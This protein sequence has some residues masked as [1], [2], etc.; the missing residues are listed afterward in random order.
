MSGDRLSAALVHQTFCRVQPCS[1]QTC[2]LCL[3]LFVT[4][5]H[6]QYKENRSCGGAGAYFCISTSNIVVLQSSECRL[7]VALTLHVQ[8]CATTRLQGCALRECRLHLTT[9]PCCSVSA[10]TW[11]A[12]VVNCIRLSKNTT[13][14]PYVC[15]SVPRTCIEPI[16][17][18]CYIGSTG[19]R[20]PQNVHYTHLLQVQHCI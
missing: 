5:V 4:A 19:T 18:L 20:S 12:E 6:L 3:L 2:Y 10:W 1:H 7:P 8:Y 13:T 14:L 16:T 11:F 17:A 15:A 9:A